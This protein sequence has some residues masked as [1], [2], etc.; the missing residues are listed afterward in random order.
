MG[1]G[2]GRGMGRVGGGVEKCGERC[3]EEGWGVG[4]V[5]KDVG[6]GVR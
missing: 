3:E 1:E 6:R 5:R 2:E 4:E